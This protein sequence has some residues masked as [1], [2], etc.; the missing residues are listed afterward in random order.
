MMNQKKITDKSTCP[1][2]QNAEE[3]LTSA[4]SMNRAFRKLRKSLKLCKVCE[5]QDD[6]PI[7]RDLDTQIN[8]ALDEVLEEWGYKS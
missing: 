4:Q 8:T 7:L 1:V 3:A 2:I 6:C 5:N